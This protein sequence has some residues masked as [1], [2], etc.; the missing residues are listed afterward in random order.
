VRQFLGESLLLSA[1]SIVLALCL[2]R[3][4]LP[5]FSAL[6]GVE[7]AFGVFTNPTLLAGAVLVALFTGMGAGSYPA[8]V[9]SRFL[10]SRVLR[11]THSRG[12]K[13]SAR[14]RKGLVVV[15]FAISIVLIVATF[16]AYQQLR[17]MQ[18]ADLGFDEEQVVAIEARGA[19]ETLKAELQRAASVQAVSG[20]SI[21]PGIGRAS[22]ILNY[23]FKDVEP[24]EDDDTLAY[25][26]VDV[27]Y[28]EMMSIEVLAGRTFRADRRSD[29]GTVYGPDATHTG[30]WWRGR[31][32]VIN[33][34][35]A[36]ELGVSPD[37]ALGHDLRVYQQE[38]GRLYNDV[39]GTIVGVVDDFHTGSLRTEIP[40]TVF[41]PAKLPLDVEDQRAAYWSDYLLAKVAP[42]NAATVME[43]MRAVWTDVNPE[44]PFDA[45]FLDASLNRL[46]QQEERIGR[47]IALFSGL[48]IL[49][50][51]LG[52]FGLA[53][54][55]AQ[56]RR[57]EIGI[58]KAVGASAASIVRL[59]STDFVRLV[60]V[61]VGVAAPVAYMLVQRW[62]A[63][64]AYR[65]DLGLAP[66]AVAA[67]AALVIA[68]GTVSTQALRAARVDPAKTLRSE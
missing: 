45:S 40:P 2:T 4:V 7:L 27:G 43:E 8:F 32:M 20:A 38:N 67:A 34:A 52:L 39:G 29:L 19:Y 6:L 15:Q 48:A 64:F 49:I 63:D 57:K 41:V 60:L 23:E 30:R 3:T 35:A 55:A 44:A 54:Y 36:D 22:N 58:R 50:A 31:A 65:I 28:F 68:L 14:L 9:L 33:R 56:R 51:C 25:Q 1:G 66:F 18:T 47:L 5:A 16:T 24:P 12:S 61:A 62:L 46:Y 10:P 21:R 37:A 26:L 17:Y 59:L 11:G 13:G 53:T 42:G